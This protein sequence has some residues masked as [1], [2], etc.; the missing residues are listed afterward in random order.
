MCP[1][2][3]GKGSRLVERMGVS[4]QVCGGCDGDGCELCGNRGYVEVIEVVEHDETCTQCE[5][6]GEV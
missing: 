3:G 2:C 5:G 4:R 1:S 6:S